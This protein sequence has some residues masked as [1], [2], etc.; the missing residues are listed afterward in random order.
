MLFYLWLF[1]VLSLGLAANWSGVT[2]TYNDS[3]RQLGRV[4]SGH[5]E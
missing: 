1:A 4:L 3:R 5:A 2:R